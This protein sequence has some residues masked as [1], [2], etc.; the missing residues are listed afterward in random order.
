MEAVVVAVTNAV[1]MVRT[2]DQEVGEVDL[3]ISLIPVVHLPKRHPLVGPDMVIM[4]RPGPM[5]AAGVLEAAAAEL[6]VPVGIPMAVRV[7]KVILPAIA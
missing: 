3:H 1:M 5:A 4:A 7:E 6:A 2:V